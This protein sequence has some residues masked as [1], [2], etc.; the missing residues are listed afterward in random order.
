[1]PTPSSLTRPLTGLTLVIEASTAAGGVALLNG[2]RV[3]AERAVPMGAGYSDGL[4]PGIQQ[5][6][7]EAGVVAGDVEALVCG[8]GPGSFTSLRIAASLAK[9]LAY[10]LGRPLYAVPSMLLAA[11]SLDD[12]VTG[13]LVLHADALRGERYVQPVHRDAAG[14]VIAAGPA[15]R[16]PAEELLNQSSALQRVALL[17]TPDELPGVAVVA[18]RAAMAT[19]VDG[20]WREEPVDLAT[21]EPQ[22]GRL[23]EAQVKWEASHGRALPDAPLAAG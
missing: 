5:L 4:F 18:P 12:S 2:E 20:A 21:W 22:Y 15:V 1:M 11:A 6:L 10:G 7:A 16:I 14:R 23:A 3:V 8:A 19:R 13:E 17:K 9:G